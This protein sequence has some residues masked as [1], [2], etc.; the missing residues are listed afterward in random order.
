MRNLLSSIS[1][2]YPCSWCASDFAQD[3]ERNPPDAPLPRPGQ[4]LSDAIK[5]KEAKGGMGMTNA[6][7]TPVNGMTALS[8]RAALSKWLCERH[9]EVNRKLGKSEFSCALDKLGERWKEGP[10]DGRCD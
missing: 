1:V 6:E 9:N 10:K 4:S 2:L 5:D 8:G 7:S 3:I